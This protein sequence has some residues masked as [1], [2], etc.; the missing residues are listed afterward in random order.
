M[1]FNP[2]VMTV[3][4]IEDFLLPVRGRVFSLIREGRLEEA[5]RSLRAIQKILQIGYPPSH[6]DKPIDSVK[7]QSNRTGGEN[8]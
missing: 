7:N 2:F 1:Q 3:D 4:S 8:L 5:S 6:P